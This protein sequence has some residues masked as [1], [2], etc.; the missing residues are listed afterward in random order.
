M[1]PVGGLGR[2]GVPRLKLFSF[3]L[4]GTLLQR[5]ALCS[6]DAYTAPEVQF[7]HSHS[8]LNASW[9]MSKEP[10]LAGDDGPGSK[11]GEIPLGFFE[12]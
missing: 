2:R 4:G 8:Y 1:A 11:S 9:Y 5:V 12:S 7:P 3:R 6:S 10:L